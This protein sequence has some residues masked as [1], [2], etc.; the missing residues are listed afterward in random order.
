M[1]FVD[2]HVSMVTDPTIITANKPIINNSK[3]DIGL[4]NDYYVNEAKNN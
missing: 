4:I 2:G 1:V 3:L